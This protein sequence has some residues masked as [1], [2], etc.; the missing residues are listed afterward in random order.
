M[1]LVGLKKKKKKKQPGTAIRHREGRIRP[2]AGPGH[3]LDWLSAMAPRERLWLPVRADSQAAGQHQA[4]GCD[5]G[6]RCRGEAGGTGVAGGGCDRGEPTV[7]GRKT[8]TTGVERRSTWMQYS[9]LY[10]MHAYLRKPTWYVTGLSESRHAISEAKATSEWACLQHN[11]IRGGANR[12]VLERIKASWQ[13]ILGHGVDR[14][15]ILDGAACT[16]FPW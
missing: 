8:V 1:W 10:G 6:L 16:V 9:E 4:D 3:G 15:W 13:H 2:R 5:P 11:S 12:E 14:P 7:F